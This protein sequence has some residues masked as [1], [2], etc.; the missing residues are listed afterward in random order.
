MRWPSITHRGPPR[1]RLDIQDSRSER[2]SPGPQ[3]LKPRGL[4]AS[5]PRGLVAS[6]PRGLVALTYVID[7]DDRS[8]GRRHASGAVWGGCVARTDRSWGGE[9]DVVTDIG[10]GTDNGRGPVGGTNQPAAGTAGDQRRAQRRCV[11]RLVRHDRHSR[12]GRQRSCAVE[13]RR[14]RSRRAVRHGLWR[15]RSKAARPRGHEATRLRGCEATRL[16]E[17]T[18]IARSGRHTVRTQSAICS[19]RTDVDEPSAV[20]HELHWTRA[21]FAITDG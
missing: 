8:Q 5:W 11:W 6:W 20:D 4:L 1:R 14:R 9:W 18:Q 19:R 21:W 16:D 13:H 3:A 2:P 7:T 17:S 15:G 10:T 12:A